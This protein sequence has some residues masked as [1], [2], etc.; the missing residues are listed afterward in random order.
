MKEVFIG[1][2]AND[3]PLL[4]FTLEYKD[5][6]TINVRLVVLGVRSWA[7]TFYRKG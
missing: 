7:I 2:T 6:H 5:S 4:G 1:I 3:Q